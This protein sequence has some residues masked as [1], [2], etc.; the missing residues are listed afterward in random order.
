[1]IGVIA[2]ILGALLGNRLYS[3]YLMRYF[4]IETSQIRIMDE[5]GNCRGGFG[6]EWREPWQLSPP[7]DPVKGLFPS[8]DPVLTL[9]DEKGSVHTM[10]MP[11][12]LWILD[13]EG[14]VMA[15]LRTF[16]KGKT[17]RLVIGNEE[18]GSYVNIKYRENTKIPTI[19]IYS[20][21]FSIWE[22][23]NF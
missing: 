11:E 19:N 7:G 13:N 3:K 20:D 15:E 18:M 2:G 6:F 4:P 14:K 23:D 12:G 8:N 10:L 22:A 16:G 21:D 9:S 17:T 5:K 1:M